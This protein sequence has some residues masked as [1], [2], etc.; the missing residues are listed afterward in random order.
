MQLAG[1][2]RSCPNAIRTCLIT[3]DKN[4]KDSFVKS[5]YS[6]AVIQGCWVFFQEP[7]NAHEFVERLAWKT[8]GKKARSNYENFDPWTLHSAFEEAIKDLEEKNKQIERN[9]EK[10]EQSCKDEEKK[11][12][13]RVADLQRKNQVMTEL[14]QNTGKKWQIYRGKIR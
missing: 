1:I 5:C 6:Y 7:F 10:L 9:I 8:I 3:D 4:L 13:Q 14:N 11:H 2:C 12:W